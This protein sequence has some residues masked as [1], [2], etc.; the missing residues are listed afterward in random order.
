MMRKFLPLLA[1]LFMASLAH[2]P[3]RAHPL[4]STE[5]RIAVA[6]DEL[7][8]AI[9]LPWPELLL[10]LPQAGGKSAQTLTSRQ[11]AALR[12][13]F[14]KHL[15]LASSAKQAIAYRITEMALAP[16]SQEHVR[17][18]MEL[19]LGIVA[20]FK[21]DAMPTS[22]ILG[23]DAV[24]HQVPNHRAVVRWADG[25]AQAVIRYDFARKSAPALAVQVR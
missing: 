14:E 10:A 16:A 23:Y 12:A 3:A 6:G 17:A 8:L 15:A 19:R 18:Y 20:P 1:M 22:I 5:I 2:L 24:I 4:P 13:Y 25:K 7:Q 21:A 9:A 11:E